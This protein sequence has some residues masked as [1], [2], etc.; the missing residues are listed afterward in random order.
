MKHRMNINL[1][2]MKTGETLVEVTHRRWAKPDE[3]YADVERDLTHAVVVP[4]GTDLVTTLQD[5]VA[6]HFS[7]VTRAGVVS[8]SAE[9]MWTTED[10]EEAK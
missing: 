5:L 6:H 3:A 1:S 10:A 8:M 4:D 2:R 9:T 7:V